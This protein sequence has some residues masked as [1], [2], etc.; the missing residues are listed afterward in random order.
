MDGLWFVKSSRLILCYSI[1]WFPTFCLYSQIFIA[2][3]DSD[4]LVSLLVNGQ[5]KEIKS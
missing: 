1:E 2:V 3:F 4:L 5:Y